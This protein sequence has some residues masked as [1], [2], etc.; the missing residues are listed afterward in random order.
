ML[1]DSFHL[2]FEIGA[3]WDSAG[4]GRGTMMYRFWWS[5][6]I[7]IEGNIETLS[8]TALA[9]ISVVIVYNDADE[10]DD[11]FEAI[12]YSISG[13]SISHGSPNDI[14][15]TGARSPSVSTLDSTHVMISYQEDFDRGKAVVGTIS[16][17]SISFVSEV[18]FE[19]TDTGFCSANTLDS[20]HALL[21]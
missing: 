4:G 12:V 11:P 7:Y 15:N 16:G 2:H 17:S 20:T 18:Q 3:R 8:S 5:I 10:E 6:H 14:R 9:S 21:K 19:S 13:D 1:Y